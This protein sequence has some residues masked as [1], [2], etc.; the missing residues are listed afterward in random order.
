MLGFE[1]KREESAC[2]WDV[3]VDE[4]WRAST[5]RVVSLQLQYDRL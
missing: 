5:F 3:M 4:A 1:K 2:P